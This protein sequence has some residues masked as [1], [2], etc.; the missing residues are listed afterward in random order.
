MRGPAQ[1]ATTPQRLPQPRGLGVLFITEMWERFSYYGMRALLV[2]YL[3]ASTSEVL[4]DGGPNANPGFGWSEEAAFT[5]Y[6][7]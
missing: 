1:G 2:L 3:I 6:G 4:P 7:I 5:L